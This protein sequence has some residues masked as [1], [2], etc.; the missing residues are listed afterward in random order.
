MSFAEA[1]LAGKRVVVVEDEALVAILIEEL[2][3]DCGCSVLGPCGTLEAALEV[4]RTE[5]FDMAVL[6]VNLRG[7]KVY[8]VA[9]MLTER[10]VPFLFLSGYGDGAIPL[11]RTTWKVCAKP[12]KAKDLVAMLSAALVPEVH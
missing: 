7:V 5:T 10:H 8:P 2:L 11:G 12:F 6:D 3:E 9:D 1:G 4:A